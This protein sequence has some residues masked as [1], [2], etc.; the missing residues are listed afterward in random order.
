MVLEM[1][2]LEDPE[3]REETGSGRDLQEAGTKESETERRMKGKVD[4]VKL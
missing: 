2:R 1:E 4:V 3:L